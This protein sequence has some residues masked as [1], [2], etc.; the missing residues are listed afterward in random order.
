MLVGGNARFVGTGDDL[1]VHV[2]VIAGIDDLIPLLLQKITEYV[3][4]ERLIAVPDMRLARNG[5]A[6]CVHGYPS[7]VQRHEFLF[8]ARQRI[9]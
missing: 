8:S 2:G 4:H 7:F 1:I 5:D 9:I 3:V 6:A